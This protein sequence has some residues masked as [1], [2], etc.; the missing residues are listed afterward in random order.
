MA[1]ALKDLASIA[2]L[3]RGVLFFTRFRMTCLLLSLAGS[4]LATQAQSLAWEQRW[5]KAQARDIYGLQLE[6]A[7]Q[8]RWW[9]GRNPVSQ[10]PWVIFLH[11]RP[12]TP[13]ARTHMAWPNHSAL[14]HWLAEEG[15]GL[16]VLMRT[17]YG[18]SSGPDLEDNGACWAKRY[19]EALQPGL[20]QLQSA[21]DWLS[22]RQA[23]SAKVIVMGESHGGLMALHAARQL[24]QV[25]ASIN[26]SGGSGGD[27]WFFPWRPCSENAL[28]KA[29][30]AAAPAT[31]L[32]AKP[33]LWFYAKDDDFWGAIWP[34]RWFESYRS[35]H[36]VPAMT[37]FRQFDVGGHRLV[38]QH[39][40][41][42]FADLK[43]FLDSL[44]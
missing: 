2:R 24:P 41:V 31:S 38:S 32:T 28:W 29:F 10:K 6:A 14:F 9:S 8:M 15:Y 23:G 22:Q 12:G 1:V 5:L 3:L 18:E 25:V 20:A 42:L 21:I 43:L 34:Q 7:F 40:K 27:P 26:I 39:A 36:P 35:A 33:S 13:H 17:G 11:G 16:I 19:E 30:E 44:N 37:H 4:S